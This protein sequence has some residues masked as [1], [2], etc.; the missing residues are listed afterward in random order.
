MEDIWNTPVFVIIRNDNG[1]YGHKI[2]IYLDGKVEGLMPDEQY[3]VINRFKSIYDN[4]LA[5][6][7]RPTSNA[8][9][10]NFGLSQGTAP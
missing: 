5:K 6:S 3:V 9:S 7:A 4:L 8:K 1:N 2:S 10:D